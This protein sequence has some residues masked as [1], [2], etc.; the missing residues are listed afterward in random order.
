MAFSMS[1]SAS[2]SAARQSLN[3]ALVRSRNSFTSLAGISMAVFGVLILFISGFV[4]TNPEPLFISFVISLYT[5]AC[6]TA[7]SK[8]PRNG[9]GYFSTRRLL[10]GFDVFRRNRSFYRHRDLFRGWF[11]E[12]AFLLFVLFVSAGVH[13]LDAIGQCLIRSGLL[14]ANLRLLVSGFAFRHRFRN[15]RSEKPNCAQR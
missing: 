3:P 7:R 12:I 5:T 9:P 4:S 8:S 11:H 14:F 10:S 2:T 1:P 13:V 15:F 6:K